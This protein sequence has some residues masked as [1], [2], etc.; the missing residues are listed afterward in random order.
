MATTMIET[1][2]AQMPKEKATQFRMKAMETFGYNKGAI[3]KAI[4]AAIEHWIQHPAKIEKKEK[5]NWDVLTGVLKD[6]N[7]PSVE[8]QHAAFTYYLKKQKRR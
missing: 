8:L 3:S 4:N 6:I 2:R 7:M 5:P 1:I